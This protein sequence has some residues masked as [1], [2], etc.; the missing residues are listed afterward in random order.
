MI[1]TSFKALARRTAALAIFLGMASLASAIPSTISVSGRIDG[2]ARAIDGTF[3]A[4]IDFF[5]TKTSTTVVSTQT[6]SIT[7]TSGV[8]S[9]SIEVPDTLLALDSLYYSVAIDLDGNGI[10]AGDTFEDRFEVTSVPYSLGARPAP[11]FLTAPVQTFP[12]IPAQLV[13]DIQVVDFVTP[14]GGLRF[15]HMSL[16]HVA[17]AGAGAVTFSYGIYDET[18]VMV[19]GPATVSFNGPRAWTINDFNMPEMQLPPNKRYYAAFATNSASV[20][21]PSS[22]GTSIPFGRGFIPDGAPGGVLPATFNPETLVTNPD[23]TT[24]IFPSIGL[25]TPPP[26]NP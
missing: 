3:T 2:N 18:G 6:A 7:V 17:G 1:P 5:E 23:P 11:V 13:N 15:S 14:P 21:V 9:A 10:D 16:A 22:F 19:A 20:Q 4:Q 8:F 26:P 24:G 12:T 25:F